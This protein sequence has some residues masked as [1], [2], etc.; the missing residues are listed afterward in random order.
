MYYAADETNDFFHLLVAYDRETFEEIG[1]VSFSEINAT[2]SVEQ[3]DDELF[4]V[5]YGHEI[6]W[7]EITTYFGYEYF[8]FDGALNQIARFEL[9]DRG[10]IY[11]VYRVPG[12]TRLLC[13]DK[14]QLIEID[15]EKQDAVPLA[16]IVEY[17]SSDYAWGLTWL[18]GPSYHTLAFFT[19]STH[20]DGGYVSGVIVDIDK[21]TTKKTGNSETLGYMYDPDSG[22]YVRTCYSTPTSVTV[23]DKDGKDICTINLESASET[24]IISVDWTRNVLITGY[25]IYDFNSNM[26]KLKI[27][28]CYSIETG[29]LISD[30]MINSLE[31]D[32]AI[33]AIDEERGLAFIPGGSPDIYGFST[34]VIYAW[35]YMEDSIGDDDCT[36]A[37]TTNLRQSFHPGLEELRRELEDTYGIN[38]YM[39]KEIEGSDFGY[40]LSVVEYE[41]DIYFG[42]TNIKEA[43]SIY[44][45]GFFK[46]LSDSGT[47]KSLGFYL[48]GDIKSIGDGV[49]NAIGLATYMGYERSLALDI[50]Y[51]SEFVK[52]IHHEISHWIDRFIQDREAL[53]VISDYEEGFA[54]LNPVQN[55][56]LYS[57]D[58]YYDK[59]TYTFW[60]GGYD[61]RNMYSVDSYSRT[62]PTEDRARLFEN[63]IEPDNYDFYRSRG[64]IKKLDYYF[65]C[66]RATFDTT[67]WPEKTVWE[68]RLD[69][70]KREYDTKQKR[71]DEEKD[72]KDK[73]PGVG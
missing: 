45:D 70:W 14:Q 16:D 22:R 50:T 4:F 56:Y 47:I 33:F 72:E 59:G 37:R 27:Y 71:F 6:P 31:D 2:V 30:L 53:G 18:G 48:C 32:S 69:D 28:R 57:Y 51:K 43:L 52:T 55:Y 20:V 7:D 11:N 26:G 35:D 19:D 61:Y 39:G 44:P 64:V 1:S 58:N 23:R 36:I 38:I 15:Y 65:T 46:Q 42:L 17:G 40:N 13:I 34:R 54:A 24:E 41:E 12:T 25:S 67:G 60:G 8:I 10:E 63:V 49:S 9:V 68:Q 73:G 62:F 3:I 66:I 5:C 21:G 29:E